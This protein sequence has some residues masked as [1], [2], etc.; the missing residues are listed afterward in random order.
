M[1]KREIENQRKTL[2]H[3][4]RPHH[5]LQNPLG[6]LF[7]HIM[8]ILDLWGSV[9]YFPFTI[10]YVFR[11]RAIIRPVTRGWRDG[12]AQPPGDS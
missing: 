6:Y 3:Y 4:Q 10:L 12:E 5:K 9:A 2:D 7:V 8:N 1:K 11:E